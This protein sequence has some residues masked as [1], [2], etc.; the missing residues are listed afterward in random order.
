PP[1]TRTAT[2]AGGG[3][4]ADV[5][6]D[7]FIRDYLAT[8][9][10]KMG[11]LDGLIDDPAHNWV[12]GGEA[13]DVILI[14]ARAASSF[15]LARPLSHPTYKGTWFDPLTG[16]TRDAGTISGTSGTVTVKPNDRE[17]LLLLRAA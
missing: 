6:L 12:L 11:P 8:D 3:P 17:W 10:M 16:N 5:I 15:R 2:E 13:T 14:D 7:K 4:S 1:R 9:L